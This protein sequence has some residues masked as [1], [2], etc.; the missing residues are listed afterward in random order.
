[1]P[2]LAFTSSN[3]ESDIRGAYLE[4][5]NGYLIKPATPEDL[6]VMVQAIKSF[7]LCQNHAINPA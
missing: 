5:A 4:G 7:W 1:M 3:Q 6:V 2:V